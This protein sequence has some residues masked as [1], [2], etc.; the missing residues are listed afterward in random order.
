MASTQVA[1][2]TRHGAKILAL[3]EACKVKFDE[4]LSA[5]LHWL[6]GSRY[7]CCVHPPRSVEGTHTIFL[8][9]QLQL[10]A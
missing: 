2:T 1:L 3:P 6:Q 7:S 10:R 5:P 8:V 4:D 9:T